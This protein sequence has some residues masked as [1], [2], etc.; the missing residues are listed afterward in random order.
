MGILSAARNDDAVLP[1]SVSVPPGATPFRAAGKDYY[2]FLDLV[3]MVALQRGWGFT[4]A[5]GDTVEDLKRKHELFYARLNGAG[6]TE[7][8]VE[9]VRVCLARW[10]RETSRQAP[11]ELT[12]AQAVKILEDLEPPYGEERL[13]AYLMTQLLLLRF[14]RDAF[15]TEVAGGKDEP[16][17]ADPNAQRGEGSTRNGS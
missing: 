8:H 14:L 1:S 17:E 4:G 3:G 16:G 10:Q 11:R 13:P 6:P 15:G 5:P 9:I 7:D 12:T 2:L